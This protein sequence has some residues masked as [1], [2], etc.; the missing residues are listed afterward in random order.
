MLS[1]YEI[2]PFYQYSCSYCFFTRSQLLVSWP[3]KCIPLLISCFPWSM[4]F[5]IEMLLTSSLSIS[6]AINVFSLYCDVPFLLKILF[7]CIDWGTSH[8]VLYNVSYFGASEY[9]HKLTLMYFTLCTQAWNEAKQKNI[10]MSEYKVIFKYKIWFNAKYT[11]QGGPDWPW[12]QEQPNLKTLHLA[13]AFTWMTYL[14]L[15]SGEPC[16]GD[17]SSNVPS[18]SRNGSYWSKWWIQRL[19]TKFCKLTARRKER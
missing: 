9:L 2:L 17:G 19:V 11:N 13:L 3:S 14:Y 8:K 1:L 18:P 4:Y 10:M 5:Y 7:Q 15:Q 6:I 12:T 16:G